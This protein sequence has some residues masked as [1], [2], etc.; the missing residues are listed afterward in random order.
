MSGLPFSSI[1]RDRRHRHRN[2][3]RFRRRNIRRIA[4]TMMIGNDHWR[5]TPLLQ[6]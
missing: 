5:G 6:E 4:I 3:I 2:L 1:Y